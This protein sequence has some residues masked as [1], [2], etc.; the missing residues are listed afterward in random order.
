MTAVS[1]M[2]EGRSGAQTEVTYSRNSEAPWGPMIK[3]TEKKQVSVQC[4]ELSNMNVVQQRVWGV[5][6]NKSLI[7]GGQ[8]P[9]ATSWE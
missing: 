7:P 6:G 8:M 9:D 3:V 1:T 2:R 4:R 5:T